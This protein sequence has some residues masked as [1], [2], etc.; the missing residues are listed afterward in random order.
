MRAPYTIF[1]ATCDVIRLL[2]FANLIKLKCHCGFYLHLS[3]DCA[4]KHFI[5]SIAPTPIW[6]PT[7]KLL[8]FPRDLLKCDQLLICICRSLEII[9]WPWSLVDKTPFQD[10]IPSKTVL[11]CFTYNDAFSAYNKPAAKTHDSRFIDEKKE[12]GEWGTCQRCP[13][14]TWQIPSQVL[15]TP[16]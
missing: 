3:V 11:E 2:V 14:R 7:P 9:F 6:F 1:S 13:D 12:S 15:F 8:C 5:F 16:P 10:C 4:V